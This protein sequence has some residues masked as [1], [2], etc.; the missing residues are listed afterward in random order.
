MNKEVVEILVNHN[1]SKCRLNYKCFLT[2][3][4]NGSVSDIVSEVDE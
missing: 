1:V 2:N 4:D 3:T